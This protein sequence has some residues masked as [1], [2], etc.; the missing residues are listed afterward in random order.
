MTLVILILAGSQFVE[1]TMF[2]GVMYGVFFSHGITTELLAL[3]LPLQLVLFISTPK[4]SLLILS[5]VALCAGA[6]AL[7][8]TLRRGA[9]LGLAVALVVDRNLS[10]D[11]ASSCSRSSEVDHHR[12]CPRRGS[13]RVASVQT[14]AASRATA[15]GHHDT[16]R[17]RRCSG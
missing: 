1:Y 13:G 3:L 15:V 12:N 6:A 8:L 11:E 16:D 10:R 5:A 14:R 9:I 17:S 2:D 7:L 4:R